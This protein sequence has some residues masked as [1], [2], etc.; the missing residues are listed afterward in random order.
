M[1]RVHSNKRFDKNT[2]LSQL[3]KTINARKNLRNMFQENKLLDLGLYEESAK[4]QKPTTDAIDASS[5]SRTKG[6]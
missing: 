5:R 4:L 2:Y 6:Y 3:N 1:N